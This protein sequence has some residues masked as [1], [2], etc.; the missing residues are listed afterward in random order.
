MVLKLENEWDSALKAQ[1]IEF[2]ESKT[3]ELQ[4]MYRFELDK[5]ED[6]L[7]T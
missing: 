5:Y 6:W 7:K 2:L 4:Q 3:E 1:K